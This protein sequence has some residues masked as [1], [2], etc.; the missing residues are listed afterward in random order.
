MAH[1][2]VVVGAE[3]LGSDEEEHC[4][5]IVG[6]LAEDPADVASD[7]IVVAAAEGAFVAVA[8]SDCVVVAEA[9][10]DLDYSFQEAFAQA[11]DPVA[12]IGLQVHAVEAYIGP[13][14]GS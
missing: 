1:C 8:A 3:T 10:E 6:S 11:V 4:Q 2:E 9:V 5:E 7:S 12:Y 13:W 14:V